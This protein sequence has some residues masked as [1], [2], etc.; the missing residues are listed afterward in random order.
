MPR[1]R[2][3][4]RTSHAEAVASHAETWCYAGDQITVDMSD[5]VTITRVEP[6]EPE[7]VIETVRAA[8]FEPRGSW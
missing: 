5:T 7:S 4:Y 2:V 3:Y 8:G 1:Y 6:E